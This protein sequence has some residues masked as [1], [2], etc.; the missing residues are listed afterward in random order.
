MSATL[1]LHQKIIRLVN[2]FRSN[3]SRSLKTPNLANHYVMLE[4]STYA[5][6][7]KSHSLWSRSDYTCSWATSFF[8]LL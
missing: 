3:L 1:C 6:G 5:Y 7:M 8:F 4:T 2:V